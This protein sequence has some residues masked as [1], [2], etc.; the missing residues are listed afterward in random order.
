[1]DQ[2]IAYV[3]KEEILRNIVKTHRNILVAGWQGTGKTVTALKAARG[4]ADVYYYNES[5]PDAKAYSVH[6]NETAIN[7]DTLNV[8]ESMQSAQS[9]L[10]V[11]ELDRISSA[12]SARIID[13]LSNKQ[14]HIKILLITRVLMD[15]RDFLPKVDVVVRFKQDTAEVLLTSLCDLDNI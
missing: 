15:A 6:Y 9:L 2:Q 8:T 14:E 7:L 12:A 11:D 1:M 3:I 5:E 13:L 10:I 4:V